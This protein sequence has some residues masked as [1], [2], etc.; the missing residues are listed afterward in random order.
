MEAVAVLV[1]AADSR[2]KEYGAPRVPEFQ[3]VSSLSVMN[4]TV[5]AIS[6]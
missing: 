6:R 3:V 5:S 1:L 4:V 2:T